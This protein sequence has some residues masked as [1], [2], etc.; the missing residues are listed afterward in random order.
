MTE[1]VSPTT[2]D[3]KLPSEELVFDVDDTDFVYDDQPEMVLDEDGNWV[4]NVTESLEQ[5][6]NPETSDENKFGDMPVVFAE[7]A[8]E[9]IHPE[10]MAEYPEEAALYAEWLNSLDENTKLIIEERKRA[11][12]RYEVVKGE[13]LKSSAALLEGKL[14][15]GQAEK[16]GSQKYVLG[17]NQSQVFFIE[18]AKDYLE[19]DSGIGLG[20]YGLDQRFLLVDENSTVVDSEYTERVMVGGYYQNSNIGRFIIAIPMDRREQYGTPLDAISEADAIEDF[21]QPTSEDGGRSVSPKYIAGFID[22]AGV[23]H[24]NGNFG[25]S[26]EPDFKQ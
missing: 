2:P 20:M 19:E 6:S 11:Q 26:G 25:V 21:I 23:Y 18:D 12:G 7:Y 15:A 13:I 5:P 1:F 9:G 8:I 3:K 4:K 10:D 17:V 24:E 16:L 14:P 22:S